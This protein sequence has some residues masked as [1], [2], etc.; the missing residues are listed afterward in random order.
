[1]SLGTL[2][3]AIPAQAALGIPLPESQLPPQV[4]LIKFFGEGGELEE[5]CSGTLLSPQSL[6]SAGH[7]FQGKGFEPGS[8]R[9]PRNEVL[10][11]NG[12]RTRVSEVVMGNGFQVMEERRLDEYRRYDSAMA[13]LESAVALPAMAFLKD[14]KAVSALLRDAQACAIFGYG[15]VAFTDT[16]L[17]QLRG[18]KVLPAAVDARNN[19]LVYVRGIGGWNSG[20]V[21]G[22]DSG[23]SLACRASADAPWVHIAV[24]SARDYKHGSLFA[25]HFLS[26]ELFERLSGAEISPG[27]ERKAKLG[28]LRR[29]AGAA[30]TGLEKVLSRMDP[31]LLADLRA[32]LSAFSTLSAG[33][34]LLEKLRAARLRV[35]KESLGKPLRLH[36]FSL[37]E[38]DLSAVE[39][40]GEEMR[41]EFRAEKNPFSLGDQAAN[42]FVA[43]KIEGNRVIGQL[44][45]YGHSDYFSYAGCR[46]NVICVPGKF[47]NVKVPLSALDPS[48]LR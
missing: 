29:E 38:L 19:G 9:P 23:G 48:P 4:C 40:Q 21:E 8:K 31:A 26:T 39:L 13:R 11:P 45:V 17:E 25:P 33:E 30:F 15:G 5:I 24:T 44:S 43:E 34:A 12:Q 10:C 2:L 1:M 20:L 22:G 16:A 7:C 37:V 42:R 46:E 35:L 27:G 47:L 36:L 6:V 41:A 32:E 28:F 18:T 3:F 14:K